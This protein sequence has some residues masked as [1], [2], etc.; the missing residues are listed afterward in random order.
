M[1][2]T[3]FFKKRKTEEATAEGKKAADIKSAR[4]KIQKLQEEMKAAALAGNTDKYNKLSEELQTAN[5]AL[6]VLS[7]S[8]NT[9][10]LSDEE[11]EKAWKNYTED[12]NKLFSAQLAKYEDAKKTLRKELRKLAE[13]QSTGKK[14]LVLCPDKFKNPYEDLKTLDSGEAH[15]AIKLLNNILTFR[16]SENIAAIFSGSVIED[17][18]NTPTMNE[19]MSE[20][21][22]EKTRKVKAQRAE[23]EKRREIIKAVAEGK[24]GFD[25]MYWEDFKGMNKSE[26]RDF[27]YKHYAP[28]NLI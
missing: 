9:K 6:Y 22:K 2:F 19:F 8:R 7:E 18:D 25:A 21:G 27:F 11:I 1:L 13:I 15:R 3:D 20:V 10:A 26:I 5:N 14:E 24:A 28:I 23:A 4:D 17:I 16:E 12:Y